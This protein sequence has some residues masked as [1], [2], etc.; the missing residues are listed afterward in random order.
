MKN[1]AVV[2][3]TSL[4]A[5]LIIALPGNSAR[6]E[7]QGTLNLVIMDPLAAPLSCPCVKGYAQRNYKKLAVY[8]ERELDRPFRIY[9]HESLTTVLEEKS[10][11]RADIVIGKRSVVAAEA[12][13][14]KV[15]LQPILAL[16]GK[17]GEIGRAHV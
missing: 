17:D 12:A 4:L 9:F 11:G 10:N 2:L 1:L 7:E 16:T 8:L 14:G 3:L 13:E 15:P 5:A 6:S